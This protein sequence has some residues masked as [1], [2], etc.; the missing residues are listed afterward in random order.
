MAEIKIEDLT[1]GYIDGSGVFDVLMTAVGSRLEEQYQEDRIKGSDYA[2]AYLGAMQYAMAQAMQFLLGKQQA[3]AQAEL[4]KAQTSLT[5]K[6]EAEIDANILLKTKE[7][8]IKDQELL[9]R[10]QEL[11]LK[12]KEIDLANK[13]I[14]LK[15]QMILVEKEKILLMKEQILE[16]RAKI[17]N[18]TNMTN[19]NISLNT[20]NIS[21]IGAEKLLLD[22][23]KITENMQTVGSG[24]GSTGVVGAQIRLYDK[25]AAGFDRDAEVKALKPI[26]DMYSVAITA[27]P[28]NVKIPSTF[29]A[30][31][32][33][34][35]VIHSINTAL[36]KAG[37]PVI[38]I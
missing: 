34:N 2:T 26:V 11:I 31:H 33:M 10:Q 1:S 6:Q 36:T 7:L 16:L 29:G 23:K 5:I 19:S 37:L 18:E 12:G 8:E 13:E 38:S 3:D 24:I 27:D 21:K 28:D 15:S 14:E 35:T 22:Q 25:Q 20:A 4:L 30:Q 32:N 9:I 17:V